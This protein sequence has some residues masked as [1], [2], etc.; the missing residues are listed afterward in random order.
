MLATLEPIIA[1]TSYL[2]ILAVMSGICFV[3]YWLDKRRAISGGR[4]VP[5]RT[6]QL[7]ALFGGWPGAFVAQRLVRHKTQKLTFQFVYWFVVIVHVGVVATAAYIL[8]R[9]S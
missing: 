5:E 4:R 7:L 1:I 9:R 8:Y 3:I 2:C 6:L